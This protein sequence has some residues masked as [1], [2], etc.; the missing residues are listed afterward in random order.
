[1]GG[2]MGEGDDDQMIWRGQSVWRVLW[3]HPTGPDECV[4]DVWDR[5]SAE[6]IAGVM[7]R[8]GCRNVRIVRWP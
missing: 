6:F 5:E 1:M 8:A 2:G 3:L 4:G 7:R